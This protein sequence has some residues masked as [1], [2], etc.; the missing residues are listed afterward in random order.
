MR[1]SDTDNRERRGITKFSLVIDGVPGC[2]RLFR[3]EDNPILLFCTSSP[4]GLRVE[5]KPIIVFLT[6]AN[7]ITHSFVGMAM[8][9]TSYPTFYSI[10]Y[11]KVFTIEYY[12]CKVKRSSPDLETDGFVVGYIL[13]SRIAE[14]IQPSG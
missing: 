10:S 5:N 2:G 13:G 14:V 11:I 7:C 8:N 3:E 6:A 12:S 1:R 9:Q 4:G